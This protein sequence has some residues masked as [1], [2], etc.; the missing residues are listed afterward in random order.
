[1]HTAQGRLRG[2]V[3][4]KH[5]GLVGKRNINWS[6]DRTASGGRLFLKNR[7]GIKKCICPQCFGSQSLNKVRRSKFSK[8]P[9]SKICMIVR[10]SKSS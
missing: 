9:V 1:M 8:G 7:Q 5:A 10:G 3:G 4:R 2:G 6:G